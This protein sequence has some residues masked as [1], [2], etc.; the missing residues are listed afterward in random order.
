M[1]DH[2]DLLRATPSLAAVLAIAGVGMGLVVLTSFGLMPL[3][4]APE[5]SLAGW[6]L[7]G[8]DLLL[9]VRETLVIATASTVVACA[10]GLAVGSLV[11]AAGPGVRLVRAVAVVVLALPHLVGAASTGLLLRDA[12]LAERVAG[13]AG[14]PASAGWPRLVGGPWPVATVLEFAWKESAFVALVVVA[15]LGAT[16]VARTET[17][18]A[19]GATPWQRWRRVLV[20]ASL[21]AVGASG[22]IVFV[23]T[24]GNYEVA[25]LLGRAYP[26]PLPV[27]AFRLFTSVDL[28]DRPAAAAAA[29]VTAALALGTAVVVAVLLPSL[30]R[31]L[32]HGVGAGG[33]DLAARAGAAR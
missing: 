22:L 19:L 32:G 26:E 2:R 13:A 21:P 10:I 16:H 33:S 12:G 18:A 5:A 6:R 8:T 3:V 29:A 17:A 25:W 11:L 20:P 4:G 27:L 28:T 31:A 30:A 14:L 23:Y 24:V 1:T 7:S 15:A 9:G